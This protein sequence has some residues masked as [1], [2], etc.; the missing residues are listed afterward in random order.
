[1]ENPAEEGN[2]TAERLNE[3][4]WRFD[5]I[6][7]YNWGTY[8]HEIWTL[9]LN[10]QNGFLTGETGSG[11][12]SVVDAITTL[13]VPQRKIVYNQA[14]GSRRNERSL[15]T[16]VLGYYK[17]SDDDDSAQASP[18]S[19]R[20][21]KDYSVILTVF[22]NAQLKRTNGPASVLT[23]AQVLW[24]D[25]SKKDGASHGVGIIYAAAERD[26]SIREDFSG[27]GKTMSDLR[28]RLRRADVTL[29]DT[30]AAYSSW[31]KQRFGMDG[32]QAIDLFY[33]TESMKTVDDITAFVQKHMLEPFDADTPIEALISHFRDLTAAYEKVRRADDMKKALEPVSKTG[34][35]LRELR[36]EQQKLSALAECLQGYFAR[37]EKEL[38]EEDLKKQEDA[39][40]KI[41]ERTAK[42]QR[43]ITEYRQRQDSL[44]EAI[45]ENG[46]QR[47][48]AIASELRRC[49][50]RLENIRKKRAGCASLLKILGAQMPDSS[51]AF[52]EMR[53][54]AQDEQKRLEKQSSEIFERTRQTGAEL[55]GIENERRALQEELG[56]LKDRRSN[57]DAAQLRIRSLLCAELGLEESALPF[58]GELI[59]VR[60][61]EKEVWEGA[62]ER[63]MRPFAL[64]MLVSEQDYRQVL[65]YVDTHNLRGRLV[66]FRVKDDVSARDPE[67][68]PR[69]LITKLQIRPDTRFADF[70]RDRLNREFNYEC[71]TK[72]ADFMAMPQAL[73][74]NGQVKRPGGRHE[75]DD[76]TQ[77]NDRRHF[78]LGWSNADKLALI[79]QKL[80]DAF[81]RS[82]AL[83]RQ[84][85]DGK[86]S[87]ESVSKR[88]ALAGQL[89]Q[90]YDSY[91]E[92][93]PDDVKKTRE[94]LTKEKETIEKSSNVLADL[95]AQLDEAIRLTGDREEDLRHL[96]IEEGKCG[97]A[98]EHDR[99]EIGNLAD[100]ISGSPW[101]EELRPD[102]DARLEKVLKTLRD[103]RYTLM[104]APSAERA[105]SKQLSEEQKSLEEKA[106]RRRDKLI[107]LMSTFCNTYPPESADFDRSEEALPAYEAL[108]KRIN[109]DDLPRYKEDF[110]RRLKSNT[111]NAIAS[112][113]AQ[114]EER[115]AQIKKRIGLINKTLEGIEYDPG[116][117][118]RLIVKDSANSAIRDFRD[119][120][121]RC[122][123]NTFSS[124]EAFYESEAKF[125]EVKELVDRLRGREGSSESDLS[126]RRLVTD[127]RKW[128]RFAAEELVDEDGSQRDYF[129]DSGGKSGGQKEKLAYTILAAALAYQYGSAQDARDN[130]RTFRFLIIDEAFGRGSEASA[131]YGLDLFRRLNLQVLVVT[132]LSKVGVME[133]FVQH[134]CLARQDKATCRS[135]LTN[136]TIEEFRRRQA[137][138]RKLRSL[139][140][141]GAL[142]ESVSTEPLQNSG[143]GSGGEADTPAEASAAG[144]PGESSAAKAQAPGPEEEPRY[145]IEEDEDTDETAGADE[146]AEGA[147]APQEE[148]S[149]GSAKEA[150]SAKTVFELL[151]TLR[152]QAAHDQHDGGMQ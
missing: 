75:K 89:L 137:E 117:H 108:L 98:A 35:E 83:E 72:M 65:S 4:G 105:V 40:S 115:C 114:L 147:P 62:I 12:S 113:N 122:T 43:L 19:L 61:E 149:E 95:R 148:N 42:T 36:T 109:D 133:K 88:E 48:E 92:L 56:L 6:E 118:I 136:M 80:S 7:L 44:R 37:R 124:H 121:R 119:Q 94:R 10:G 38:F 27:F 39:L 1:M 101:N 96:S 68:S 15:R 60:D 129:E 77:L 46:G 103:S 141:A 126:W 47:L 21:P 53:R 18:K 73:T 54:W 70:I 130:P 31:F 90:G 9:P 22:K 25:E 78:V 128:F 81:E 8:D 150:E 143:S 104:T 23:L 24:P 13:L 110:R 30:F 84:L 55:A 91:D 120:L 112:L 20:G 16:Y 26:L 97:G 67:Y 45:N 102:L 85:K 142:I 82:K 135:S 132:P 17:N 74:P 86:E 51:D 134:I 34:G 127:V 138:Q 145:V 123:S 140:R 79:S 32:D 144:A 41:K 49:D 58:A 66:Y 116:C 33:Q 52:V 76:R 29:F 152:D 93:N 139:E 3:D 57:I 107:D 28:R 100:V 5:R 63:V 106:G 131:S 87:M 151:N 99:A 111:I 11:K 64:S 71:C 2:L 146:S 50:E 59:Q 125:R 69:S 14:A